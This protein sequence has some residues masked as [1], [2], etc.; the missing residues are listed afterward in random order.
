[1]GYI[2]DFRAKERLLAVSMIFTHTINN[3]LTRLS[4][5]SWFASGEK[6]TYLPKAKAETNNNIDLR[7]T[8]KSLIIWSSIAS[9]FLM[10]IFG[11]QSEMPFF[12]QEEKRVVSFT[13]WAEYYLQPNTVGRHWHEQT[14]ICRQLF[15]G[16]VVG[17]RPM[18]R[19]SN[20]ST[21][22]NSKMTL[23]H[24]HS[25]TK[26]FSTKEGTTLTIDSD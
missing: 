5:I 17:F 10:N 24:Y 21:Q 26:Q 19:K 15:A 16:H 22:K 23:T 3:Y 13:H 2:G 20:W 25:Y 7:D 1:M 11:K 9:L 14:I 6:I 4:K 18:K 8:D 12:T